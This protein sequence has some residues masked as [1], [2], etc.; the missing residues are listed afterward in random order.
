MQNLSDEEKEAFRA[1]VRERF[2]AGKQAQ[3]SR[4]EALTPEERAKTRREWE[5]MKR[6]WENMSEQQRQEFMAQMRERFGAIRPVNEVNEV[7]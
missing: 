1:G 2:S 7:K 3:Q 4:Y 5:E 6:K